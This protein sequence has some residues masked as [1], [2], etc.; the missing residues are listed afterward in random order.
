MSTLPLALSNAHLA[1]VLQLDKPPPLHPAHV[2][3]GP[4]VSW[5][6]TLLPFLELN[7]LYKKYDLSSPWNTDTNWPLISGMFSAF[8]ALASSVLLPSA[9]IICRPLSR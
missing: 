8:G 1:K 5:R 2:K 6:V 3:G 4:E 9:K 7:D